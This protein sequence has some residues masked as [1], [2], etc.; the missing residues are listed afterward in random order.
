MS[1][2]QDGLYAKYNVTRTDGDPEGKHAECRN[3]VLDPDHDPMSRRALQTYMYEATK[4]GYIAL[5]ADLQKWLKELG[6]ED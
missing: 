6:V 1:S 5:A 2:K 3:F 4:S